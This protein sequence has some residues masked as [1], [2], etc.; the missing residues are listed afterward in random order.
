MT[1]LEIRAS[2]WLRE[3]DKLPRARESVFGYLPI[4]RFDDPASELV[5]AALDEWFVVDEFIA[6]EANPT[7]SNDLYFEI[8]E[9]F[10]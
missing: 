3:L 6:V 10:D 1:D 8:P 5:R 2:N 9:A 7:G 4:C